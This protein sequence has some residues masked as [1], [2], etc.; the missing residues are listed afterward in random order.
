MN[1]FSFFILYPLGSKTE[2]KIEAINVKAGTSLTNGHTNGHSQ[3]DNDSSDD[4]IPLS[5]LKNQTT[6]GHASSNNVLEPHPD[7]ILYTLDSGE[8]IRYDEAKR[9]LSK[10]NSGSYLSK[11]M[12]K[13]WVRCCCDFD[14]LL[15]YK[16]KKPLL[17]KALNMNFFKEC[18]PL[19]TMPSI[20]TINGMSPQN[21]SEKKPFRGNQFTMTPEERLQSQLRKEMQNLKRKSKEDANM[22]S[23][24]KARESVKKLKNLN[25]KS[26]ILQLNNSN[27]LETMSIQE[28]RTL[29]NDKIN[30]LKNNYTLVTK[31]GDNKCKELALVQLKNDIEICREFLKNIEMKD[32]ENRKNAIQMKADEEKRQRLE[33]IRQRPLILDAMRE[34]ATPVEDLALLF[35]SRTLCKPKKIDDFVGDLQ[36][37]LFNEVIGIYHFLQNGM[38]DKI[39][40]FYEE[41]YPEN[42]EFLRLK[43]VYG[44][45]LENEDVDEEATGL[46]WSNL[47]EAITSD[48]PDS[49]LCDILFVLLP[50]LFFK[51]RKSTENLIINLKKPKHRFSS[52]IAAWPEYFLHTKLY[53]IE[54]DSGSLSE[55]IRLYLLG[56]AQ[57]LRRRNRW[58]DGQ[59]ETLEESEEEKSDDEEA[60]KKDEDSESKATDPAAGEDEFAEP[61]TPQNPNDTINEEETEKIATDSDEL[62]VQVAYQFCLDNPKIL[63]KLENLS[64]FELLPAEKI[65]I[66]N[67][68][69]NTICHQNM[70]LITNL[71][72]EEY[73]I[74]NELDQNKFAE[75]RRVT[76]EYRR[77]KFKLENSLRSTSTNLFKNMK[78]LPAAVQHNFDIYLKDG[79]EELKKFAENGGEVAENGVATETSENTEDT[80]NESDEETGMSRRRSRRS[81]A[82]ETPPKKK[83]KEISFEEK[84]D[85]LLFNKANK[86]FPNR[87]AFV[88]QITAIEEIKNSLEEIKQDLEDLESKEQD[89]IIEFQEKQR[90]LQEEYYA[91]QNLCRLNPIGSDRFNRNYY[92]FNGIILVEEINDPDIYQQQ[93]NFPKISPELFQKRNA[94]IPQW[95]A[96]INRSDFGAEYNY[97][98]LI[99][100]QQ[101]EILVTGLK[102]EMIKNGDEL[103]KKVEDIKEQEQ[104]KADMKDEAKT[105]NDE[106]EDDAE[107]SELL[108][109]KATTPLSE[110]WEIEAYSG[111]NSDPKEPIKWYVFAN[112]ADV[113]RLLGG[114]NVRGIRERNLYKNLLRWLEFNNFNK[115]ADIFDIQ[116]KTE[117]SDLPNQSICEKMKLVAV[118]SESKEEEPKI[119]DEKPKTPK[120][121][122]RGRRKKSV[123]E[124][125]TPNDNTEEP[126]HWD[127]D[128]LSPIEKL[129]YEVIELE[130]QTMNSGF[131]NFD[132]SQYELIDETLKHPAPLEEGY[133]Y[134]AIDL[135]HLNVKAFNFKNPEFFEDLSKKNV[136]KY[137]EKYK[138]N[139]DTKF[140]VENDGV[141]DEED[142]SSTGGNDNNF[143]RKLDLLKSYLI[144]IE[145]SVP[146]RFYMKPFGTLTMKRRMAKREKTSLLPEK[147]ETLIMNKYRKRFEMSVINCH[148]VSQVYVHMNALKNLIVWQYSSA[149]ALC[150]HCRHVGQSDQLLFCDL[151]NLAFHTYWSSGGD[152]GFMGYTYKNSA[153]LG[154]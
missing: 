80:A 115:V 139:V 107:N 28:A 4:D 92:G 87:E 95:E 86:P 104:E 101:D 138:V 9:P 63:K 39:I 112:L 146:Y 137:T 147:A 143:T 144:S 131:G 26:G 116:K 51:L 73:N 61:L 29:A 142:A 40:N 121:R 126:Q 105:E 74:K 58:D 8:A 47:I 130:K 57:N 53:E 145:K 44:E 117:E 99:R 15:N 33:K 21:T 50:L 3:P 124:D 22:N 83:V 79:I 12:I 36:V 110:F 71:Q 48:N 141:E 38:L 66:L 136:K 34:W 84:V 91:N 11:E 82:P 75:N 42:D 88:K 114:L 6:N 98:K 37:E 111:Q 35:E 24:K 122:G 56:S 27:I 46:L 149:K 93:K 100:A 14:K 72:A 127:F 60:E 69:I 123:H 133:E 103:I 30:L 1:F 96:A 148:S 109:A 55:L 94:L 65:S 154:T 43:P 5:A 102:P 7:D 120:K 106:M 128:N 77:N 152:F 67:C 23:I 52:L 19:K 78:I 25:S 20:T 62:N 81:K 119:E 70:E 125:N 151:C 97:V 10:N 41:M 59:E 31:D 18:H 129:A 68:L 17:T 64:I 118:K 140:Y 16:L 2:R 54:L 45:G 90:A 153:F 108:V 76:N 132:Y 49:Y 135:F 134:D 113:T 85:L 32:R 150:V 89:L 13:Y